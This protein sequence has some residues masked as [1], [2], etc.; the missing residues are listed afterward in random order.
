MKSI[1][2][3]LMK[4][5]VKQFYII[6][7][8]FLLFLFI[9]FFGMVNGGQLISY[10]QSLISAMLISPVFMGAV[11]FAWLL[12]NIKCIRFF[13]TSIR[14]ANSTYIYALKSLPHSKQWILYGLISKLVYMPVLVYSFFVV[15]MAINKSMMLIALL[16]AIYQVLMIVLSAWIIYSTINRNTISTRVEKIIAAMDVLKWIK[17]GYHSFL[18]GYIFSTKKMAFGMVKIFS[19]LLLFVSFVINGDHFDE[20]LF[21]IF[22]LVIFVAHSVLVFYC[23]DFSESLL[24]FSR[25]LPISWYKIAR[26]YLFTYCI[27]LLPELIFMLLN[28]HGNLPVTD[29]ILV[30]FTVVSTLFL[31]TAI[32]YGC[33]LNMESYQF[34]LFSIFILIFFLQKTEFKLLTFLGILLTAG[35]VFKTYYYDF[36]RE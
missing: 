27:F 11:W 1:T 33:G 20:D 34:F 22:C 13:T 9:F 25:N 23:V 24:Q 32:L 5:L 17:P 2:T 6:N 29:I 18:A 7:G 36:E 30:Y 10:H 31:C 35:V 3:F 16:V 8:G 19:I 4:V 26:T 14:A 12:Y 21:S 28:N 15:Y